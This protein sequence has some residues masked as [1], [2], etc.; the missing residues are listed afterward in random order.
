ME[1]LAF[2]DVLPV[3]LAIADPAN[4]STDCLDGVLTAPDGGGTITFSDGKLGDGE[5]CTVTPRSRARR[6]ARRR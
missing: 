5:T 3:G 4:A 2:T 6:S 1:D